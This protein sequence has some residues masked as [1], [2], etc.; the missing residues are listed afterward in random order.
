MFGTA[1]IIAA[2]IMVI[3]LLISGVIVGM[4]NAILTSPLPFYSDSVRNLLK[5]KGTVVPDE[6]FNLWMHY[7]VATIAY[8]TPFIVLFSAWILV[9][10]DGEPTLAVSGLILVAYHAALFAAM[11]VY[12]PNKGFDWNNGNY[13]VKAFAIW[14][15][16]FAMHAIMLTIT[17]LLVLIAVMGSLAGLG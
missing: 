17:G 16:I 7:V 14:S 5:T 8:V 1:S 6:S 4:V 10:P 13:S 11:F 15:G 9:S 2:A 12:L 3:I